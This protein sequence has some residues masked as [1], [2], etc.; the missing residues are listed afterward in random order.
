MRFIGE[1]IYMFER[2]NLQF[3]CKTLSY[4]RKN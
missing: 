4:D 3:E 2:K 1:R